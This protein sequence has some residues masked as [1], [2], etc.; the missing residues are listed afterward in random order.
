MH[1][2]SKSLPCP[3]F[4]AYTTAECGAPVKLNSTHVWKVNIQLTISVTRTVD[5]KLPSLM[6]TPVCLL[7]AELCYVID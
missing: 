6:V 1:K 4:R 7:P 3:W 2:F 5:I